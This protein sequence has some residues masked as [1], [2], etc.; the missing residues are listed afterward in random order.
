[1]SYVEVRKSKHVKCHLEMIHVT[2]SNIKITKILVPDFSAYLNIIY[3]VF[4]LKNKDP[5]LENI[6][7]RGHT[8]CQVSR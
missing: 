3:T 8:L 7:V 6:R 1:M 2:L 5:I 4:S